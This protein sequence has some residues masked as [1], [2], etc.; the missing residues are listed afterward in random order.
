MQTEICSF[1]GHFFFPYVKGSWGAGGEIQHPL[2]NF[3]NAFLRHFWTRLKP[4]AEDFLLLSIQLAE[5]QPAVLFQHVQVWEQKQGQTWNPG[6]SHWKCRCP[7]GLLSPNPMPALI[8]SPREVRIRNIYTFMTME[9]E[10]SRA[11]SEDGF[12]G[13]KE[14]STSSGRVWCLC[15]PEMV[16]LLFITLNHS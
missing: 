14:E 13:S 16:G 10:E 1:P 9:G 11:K 4:C 6:H 5:T 12:I 8:L 3:P 7:Q 15:V 2:A